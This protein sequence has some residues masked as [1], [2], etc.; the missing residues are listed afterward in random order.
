[1]KYTASLTAFALVAGTIATD[2]KTAQKTIIV[3][4]PED[5]DIF[6]D[7]CTT[8]TG[9]IEISRNYID[10]FILENI[11]DIIG[12]ISIP[13]DASPTTLG[14][15]IALISSPPALSS[16]TRPQSSDLS[17]MQT[18][19]ET[20][21]FSD[22]KS[23]SLFCSDRLPALDIALPGL[24]SVKYLSIGGFATRC[25]EE[26]TS[27]DILVF[28][29]RNDTEVEFPELHT[30]IGSTLIM[31]GVTSTI[32][33]F[34]NPALTSHSI[35][36]SASRPSAKPTQFEFNTEEPVEIYS[37]IETASYMWL[38]GEIKSIEL[39]NMVDFGSISIAEPIPPCN[40]TLVKIWES[41]SIASDASGRCRWEDLPRTNTESSGEEGTGDSHDEEAVDTNTPPEPDSGSEVV[42]ETE[43]QDG[44]GNTGLFLA[45]P[46]ADLG[47][48]AV[49]VVVYV[50]HT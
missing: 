3:S 37:S 6:R 1:M 17:S 35:T 15:V 39:P 23:N 30:L 29:I 50:L 45:L 13:D 5:L 32:L 31:G 36:E 38:W 28:A 33:L 40:E 49:A 2:C 25:P 48:L 18:V 21:D 42:D 12:N 47:A 24:K 19:H 26:D 16:C 8:I 9:N 20:L 44:A 46:Q 4:S 34:L 41:I 27:L 43:D 11:T 14:A 7:G 10:D 22:P